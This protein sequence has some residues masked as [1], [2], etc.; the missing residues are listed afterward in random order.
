MS[1]KEALEKVNLYI[2]SRIPFH[3]FSSFYRD[4][5]INER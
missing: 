2:S 4:N 3:V 1:A 5:T